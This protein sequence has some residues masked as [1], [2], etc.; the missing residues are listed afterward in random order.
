MKTAFRMVVLFQRI[1]Y[2]II[3]SPVRIREKNQLIEIEN[4]QIFIYLLAQIS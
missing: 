3:T 2:K 4:T 1:L